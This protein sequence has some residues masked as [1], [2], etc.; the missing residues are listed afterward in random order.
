MPIALPRNLPPNR[1]SLDPRSQWHVS[2]LIS[3][4]LETASLPSR[5]KDSSNRNTLGDMAD[6][7]N[8]LGKQRVASL[9]MSFPK[10]QANQR[11]DSRE[12]QPTRLEPPEKGDDSEALHLDV[13]FSPRDDLEQTRRSN[14]FQKPR[15]FSQL[16]THRG[17]SI[18]EESNDMAYQDDDLDRRRRDQPIQRRYVMLSRRIMKDDSRVPKL[19]SPR[20]HTSLAF[21][22]L[23]SFPRIFRDDEGDALNDRVAVTANLT[24]DT[25][26]SERLK[27]LRATITRSIGIEDREELS[28]DLADMG[29]EY[30]EGWSTGS[31]EGDD[32]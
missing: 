12:R 29:E 24:T 14:G 19:T 10:A 15:I 21:P 23:D 3:C 2:A 31:D 32:D 16:S 13:D 30:H 26:V 25:S 5:L 9:Q 7:L 18:E 6:L 20:Y 1:V 8:T 11:I 17:S 22:I 28:N 4:A 27:V